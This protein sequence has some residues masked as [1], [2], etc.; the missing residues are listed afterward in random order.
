MLR[1]HGRI[2]GATYWAFFFGRIGQIKKVPNEFICR[3]RPYHYYL[4]H[5]I[6]GFHQKNVAAAALLWLFRRWQRQT[7]N[8]SGRILMG[9]Y[10]MKK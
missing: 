4:D 5:H 2:Y 10:V 1:L 7:E 3:R 9:T 6:V 8:Y